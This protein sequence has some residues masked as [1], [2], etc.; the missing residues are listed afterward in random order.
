MSGVTA[1]L[2][3]S[4][5]LT[6]AIA[7]DPRTVYA[8][9]SNLENLPKWAPAFCLSIVREGSGWRIQTPQGPMGIRIAAPNPAGVLDHV[10]MPAPGVEV[11]VPMRV[12]PNG[13]GSEVLFT[14]FHRPDMTAEQFARDAG[15]VA[16]DLRSLKRV[17]ESAAG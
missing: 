16:Q 4:R 15:L 9:V 5:T 17:L 3:K 7:R 8:F 1:G 14:L 13:Q 6:V 12:V 11:F 2:L 10:V